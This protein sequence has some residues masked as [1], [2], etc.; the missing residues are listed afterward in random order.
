[1]ATLLHDTL[2]TIARPV[3]V[4]ELVTLAG[5]TSKHVCGEQTSSMT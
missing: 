1:L 4:G 2:S 3:S 5:L